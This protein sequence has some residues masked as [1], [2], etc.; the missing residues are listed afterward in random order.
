[1]SR[2]RRY[3]TPEAAHAALYARL[4][5]ERERLKAEGQCPKCRAPVS[6]QRYVYCLECRR[7]KMRAW[8]RWYRKQRAA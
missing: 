5:A 7:R 3:P 2:P 4:R 8:R 1:M 6:S